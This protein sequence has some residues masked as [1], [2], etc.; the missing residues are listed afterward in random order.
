MLCS[1]V[2]CIGYY[3][4]VD[5]IYL[6]LIQLIQRDQYEEKSR[7]CQAIVRKFLVVRYSEKNAVPPSHA[8][9]ISQLS[10][11]VVGTFLAMPEGGFP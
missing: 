10:L 2:V 3:S 8:G 4:L 9:E 7:Q 11:E 6:L 1:L 5:R